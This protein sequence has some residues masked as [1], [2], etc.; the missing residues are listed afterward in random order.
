LKEEKM[1][2]LNPNKEPVEFVCGG[3]IYIFKPGE[4]RELDEYTAKHALERQHAPLVVHTPMYDK[5]VAFSDAVYSQ[6]PWKKLVQMASARGIFKMG[7]KRPDLEKALEE[8]DKSQGR[9][10]PS[11]SN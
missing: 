10:L 8:Y 4:S 11:T 2:L 7:T 1:R 5:E 9:T 3:Q 6:M